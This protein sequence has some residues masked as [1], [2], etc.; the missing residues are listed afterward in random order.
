VFEE[1]EK[2]D[3]HYD[4]RQYQQDDVNRPQHITAARAAA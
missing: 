1:C 4:R 3:C 2:A